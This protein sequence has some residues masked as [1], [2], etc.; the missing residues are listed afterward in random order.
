MPKPLD[1]VESPHAEETKMISEASSAAD[2]WHRIMLAVPLADGCVVETTIR[3]FD[4]NGNVTAVSNTSCYVPGAY[5]EHD[6]EN[7]DYCFLR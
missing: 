3:H 6:P 2:R 5:V 7:P 4:T 1:I